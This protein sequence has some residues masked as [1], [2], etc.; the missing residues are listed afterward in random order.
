MWPCPPR[1]ASRKTAP[2]IP[3]YEIL[4]ELGHGGMG[5]VYKARHRKLGHLVAL[6]MILVGV[7]A[8]KQQLERFVSEA[9]AVASLR[10]PNIEQLYELGNKRASRIR[11]K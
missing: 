5:I 9:Q 7:H 4:A 6:K 3:G 11:R 2:P 10:H 8:S 1:R